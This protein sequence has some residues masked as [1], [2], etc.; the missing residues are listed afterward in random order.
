MIMEIMRVSLKMVKEMDLEYINGLMEENT[1]VSTMMIKSRQ[2]I[3]Y[4]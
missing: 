4:F 2:S 3:V 1:T